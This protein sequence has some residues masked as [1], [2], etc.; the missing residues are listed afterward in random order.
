MK[1]TAHDV[2]VFDELVKLASVLSKPF[3]QFTHCSSNV[4]LVTY[5]A[6]KRVND[7]ISDASARMGFDIPFINPMDRQ[8]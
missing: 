1:A 7:V 8:V 5:G 6:V 2:R 4:I 3:T